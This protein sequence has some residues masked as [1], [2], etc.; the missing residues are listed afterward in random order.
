MSRNLVRTPQ[1]LISIK[2][3]QLVSNYDIFTQRKT[4]W[5]N[6][7]DSPAAFETAQ[8]ITAK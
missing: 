2:S 3:V 7:T 8:I 1:Y 4:D 5:A 6:L